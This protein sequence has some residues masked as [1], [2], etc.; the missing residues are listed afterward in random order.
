MEVADR[1]AL[2]QMALSQ[3]SNRYSAL[4][5]RLTKIT[6]SLKKYKLTDSLN[7]RYQQS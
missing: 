7:K 6:L 4:V 2:L 5:V 1:Y 3:V